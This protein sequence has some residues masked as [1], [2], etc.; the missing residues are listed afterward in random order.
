ML[1]FM[2]NVFVLM[3]SFNSDFKSGIHPAYVNSV[4]FD[5]AKAELFAKDL[6]EYH[7]KNFQDDFY[8]NWIIERVCHDE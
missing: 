7:E 8:T 4:Y 2:K 1:C 5:K 6:K 3:E